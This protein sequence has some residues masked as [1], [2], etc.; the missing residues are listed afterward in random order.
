MDDSSW[1]D[2]VIGERMAVDREFT[3]QVQESRFSSQE[4]SLI[5]TATR[6]E[7]E[8]PQDPEAARIV[9]NTEHVKEILPEVRAIRRGVS[10]LQPPPIDGEE[11]A[12]QS[13]DSSVLGSIKRKFS[14]G[15]GLGGGEALSTMEDEKKAAAALTQEYAEQLQRRLESNGRWEEICAMAAAESNESGES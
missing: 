9:V 5:M 14:S 13:S 2:Q 11:Q 15:L 3:P 6:F 12:P 8:A 4:W 10:G 1:G 7:I